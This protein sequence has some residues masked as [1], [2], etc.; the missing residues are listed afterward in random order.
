MRGKDCEAEPNNAQDDKWALTWGGLQKDC[1]FVTTPYDTRSRKAE[2]RVSEEQEKGLSV[3]SG[4]HE[5]PGEWRL[6]HLKEMDWH[7]RRR[8]THFDLGRGQSILWAWNEKG[9][10]VLW[11]KHTDFNFTYSRPGGGAA[12]YIGFCLG[13]ENVAFFPPLGGGLFFVDCFLCW[14]TG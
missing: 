4:K 11:I 5:W 3:V 14:P 2:E 9:K 13:D 12:W 6:S 7:Q 1:T 8:S 10:S